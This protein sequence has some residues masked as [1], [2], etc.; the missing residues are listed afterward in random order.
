MLKKI[1]DFFKTKYK[2]GN[3]C[4]KV[5]FVNIQNMG[6]FTKCKNTFMINGTLSIVKTFSNEIFKKVWLYEI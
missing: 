2:N 4:V 3:N 6:Y 5:E 1:I